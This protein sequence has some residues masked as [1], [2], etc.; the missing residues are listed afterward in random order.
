MTAII[1]SRATVISF[2]MITAQ[3]AAVKLVMPVTWPT[4]PSSILIL[5]RTMSSASLLAILP[6]G[7]SV[8]VSLPADIYSDVAV[9]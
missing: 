1:R 2:H 5:I 8:R 4:L 3:P 7:V 9:E 6:S